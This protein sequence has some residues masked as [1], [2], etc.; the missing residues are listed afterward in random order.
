MFKLDYGIY[1]IGLIAQILFSARLLMQWVVS[2]RKRQVISPA[3]FWTTSIIAS[4]LLM[5][6]GVLRE[7]LVIIGGQLISYFIYLR[8][9]H[10]K[11]L[12]HKVP[13]LGRWLAV[14]FPIIALSWLIYA[15]KH[16]ISSILASGQVP[17]LLMLWGGMG[18][19]IFTFRFVYQWFY[20]ERRKASIIPT[21]FWV[22]SLIGS[23][24]IISYAIFRRDPVLIIG[25]LFGVVAYSRNFY[26]GIQTRFRPQPAIN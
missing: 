4:V 22:I 3:S 2:E 12:W 19:A 18:Q 15:D 24:M 14:L 20:S 10:L 17:G 5:V 23:L 7:D 8:N 26:L 13:L 6:Y 21:G 11:D 9:L 1:A 25:Q 16:S